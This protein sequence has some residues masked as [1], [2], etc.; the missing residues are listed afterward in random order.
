[1]S[2]SAKNIQ[3]QKNPAGGER[4]HLLTSHVTKLIFGVAEYSSSE[5]TV[6][7]KNINFSPIILPNFIIFLVKTVSKLYCMVQLHLSQVV[8]VKQISKSLTLHALH[9]A[10]PRDFT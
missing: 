5:N 8:R 9:A 2:G 3:K 4:I 6:Q 10:S 1:M 7:A